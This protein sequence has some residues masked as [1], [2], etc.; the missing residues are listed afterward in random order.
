MKQDQ[1]LI[2]STNLTKLLTRGAEEIYVYMQSHKC[3]SSTA[4]FQ[5]NCG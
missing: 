4:I 5:L 1:N 2:Q 3:T